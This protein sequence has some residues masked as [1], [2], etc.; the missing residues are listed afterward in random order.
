MR[1]LTCPALALSSVAFAAL[2]ACG[3]SPQGDDDDG[4]GDG[5]GTGSG[6]DATTD[7]TDADLNDSSCG[8]QNTPIAVENLGDPPDL[9]IVLDRSGS[10]TGPIPSFPPVFTPKWTIMRD[11]LNA[12]AA[13]LQDN[14]RFGLAEFPTN[15]DC[16]VASPG[17]VRVPIDLNQA[18]EIMSYFAGRNANGNTP[19][20]LGLQ[21]ALAHYQSITPNPAGRYVLFATDGDP[22]C[23]TDAATAA[24]QTVAAVTALASAGI[25]TYV[26]GFGG[27]FVD[28]SVL[29]NSA[30]AGQVPRAG[31][32][33]HYYA[34]N[35]AAELNAVLDQIAGGIIVP[36]CSYALASVPPN[37]DDVTVTL[38]GMVVPRSTQHTN[39][40]DYYPDSMTI[41]FFGTYCQ[42]ITSGAIANVS[43]VYGCPGPVID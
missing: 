33:P 3:P 39:G 13:D 7:L 14:I 40:W 5:G 32:P 34:A 31:G 11:A 17:A 8:A 6:V 43:F 22:N 10:M 1:A 9:L 37:P 30:V 41:T 18:P 23:S 16:A 27:G 12:L 35:S 19:A 42:Q 20:H 24:T 21:A 28:D 29:N 36:S 26:L 25:K 15:D 4:D 2:A 38:D